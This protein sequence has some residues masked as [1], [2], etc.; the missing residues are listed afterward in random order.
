L[1]AS[2][3]VTWKAR[4]FWAAVHHAIG[5]LGV[6]TSSEEAAAISESSEGEAEK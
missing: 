5:F 4:G 2:L 1:V 6:V 3:T